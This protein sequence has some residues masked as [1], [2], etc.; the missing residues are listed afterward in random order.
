MADDAIAYPPYKLYSR[1]SQVGFAP[2]V[3]LRWEDNERW[4]VFSY[5][6]KR[7]CAP[8]PAKIHQ[9][10]WITHLDLRVQWKFQFYTLTQK[11]IFLM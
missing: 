10:V 3:F 6:P 2:H 7:Q 11:R 9:N 5:A 8:Y 4:L 1:A